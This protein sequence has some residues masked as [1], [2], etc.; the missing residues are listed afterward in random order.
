MTS[1][2]SQERQRLLDL[3]KR[4]EEL[5]KEGYKHI[6]GVDEAGRGPLAGPVVACACILPP[7]F[8]LEGINDSKQINPD[9]RADLYEKLIEHP[10]LCYGVGVIEA[11]LIDHINILQATFQAMMAAVSRLAKKPDYVLVDGSKTPFKHIPSQAIV[12]GDAKCLSISAASIIA[13]EKRD[14]IMRDYDA[15]YPQYGFKDHKGYGTAQHLKAIE[16]YGPCP[17][18]R[19]SFEPIKSLVANREQPRLF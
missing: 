18:H 16:E 9:R 2:S 17:I 8:F 13:K 15:Q 6:A 19:R 14:A 5:R 1:L 11:L 10:E 12:Q 4:E 7:D 3:A